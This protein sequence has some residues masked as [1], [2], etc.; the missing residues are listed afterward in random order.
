MKKLILTVSMLTILLLTGCGKLNNNQIKEK[1]LNDVEKLNSY[2]MEGELK[3][4]NNDDTYNY[5]VEV[6]YSK[7]DNYKVVMTNKSNNYQQTILRNSEAVYVITPAINK[8]FKFQSE[9]PYN[10]SQAYLL[11]S[12]AT[13]LKNDQEATMEEKDKEYIFTTK[14]NYPNNPGL[15]KQRI[16]LDNNYNLKK[17]EVLDKN[18]IS[19]IEF[20]V[21]S[22]DKKAKFKDDYFEYEEQV[23]NNNQESEESDQRNTDQS[24]NNSTDQSNSNSQTTDKETT[25]TNDSNNQTEN[26]ACANGEDCTKDTE[27]TASIEDALFPLYLPTNTTLSNKEVI[28][29]ETGQRIIM[30]FEGDSPFILVQETVA[31]EPTPTVIPTYGEPFILVD[32]IGSLTDISYTWASNGIEYYIVSDVLNQNEL[33]EVAKSINLVSVINEK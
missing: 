11:N 7:G 19:N 28:S 1:F 30:T 13:D 27:K 5:N 31:K 23:E 24:T 6:S 33:L 14:V 25:S 2:Y 9:W 20:I 10:N 18:D 8:N 17:V 26:N 15:T 16:T 32:T 3:L 21:K 29:T 22:I 12:V 4:T